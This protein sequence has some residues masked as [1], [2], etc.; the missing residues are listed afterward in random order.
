MEKKCFWS[1]YMEHLN[2]LASVHESAIRLRDDTSTPTLEDSS[3]MES[4]DTQD[5]TELYGKVYSESTA[6]ADRPDPWNVRQMM[7]RTM[8]LFADRA[9]GRSRDLVPL[10]FRFIE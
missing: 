6:D 10:L 4:E 8:G 7:W 1:V 2:D 9:E 5:L 3:E